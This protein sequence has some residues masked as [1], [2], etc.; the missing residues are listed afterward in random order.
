[1]S[2][3]LVRESFYT[4]LDFPSFIFH[5][6]AGRLG[7]IEQVIK[8]VSGDTPILI[9]EN[10]EM[11]RVLIGEWID[12]LMEKNKKNVKHENKN[13]MELLELKNETFIPTCD[14]NGIAT[15]EEMTAITRHDPTDEIYKIETYC[16]RD[17][18]VANSDSL[19]IWN[20]HKLIFE[21]KLTSKVKVGDYVP[22]A[23]N[24]SAPR[25]IKN[26]ID[27]TKYFS[28]TEYLYGTDYYTAAKIYNENMV[29]RLKIRSGFWSENNKTNF[30]LPFWRASDLMRSCSGRSKIDNIKNGFVYPFSKCRDHGLPEEFPLTRRNGVFI[31]L[32][33]ADGNADK[34]G[35]SVQIT[36]ENKSVQKFV[37]DWF[38]DMGIKWEK[39]VIIKTVGVNK[40]IKGKIESIRGWSMMLVRFLTQLV[41]HRCENKYVPNEAFNAPDEFV[42]GLLDRYFS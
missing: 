28:K 12:E 30:T 25:I 1:M 22:V 24:L 39:N 15:W 9:Q 32:F 18:V 13:N 41:G 17:V 20:E 26:T 34:K 27:M 40:D 21:K 37:I 2:R 14:E 11:K 19:L 3:G 7:T 38:D 31:G 29:G 10:G 36:K 5:V 33:L 8:S 6:T 4:G 35:G 16:G 42:I 23:C